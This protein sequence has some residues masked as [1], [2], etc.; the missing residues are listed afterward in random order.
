MLVVKENFIC[1][2][3]IPGLIGTST[4]LLIGLYHSNDI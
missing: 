4:K 1:L 2:T 3:R